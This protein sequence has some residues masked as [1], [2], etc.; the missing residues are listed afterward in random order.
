[1]QLQNSRKSFLKTDLAIK[2]LAVSGMASGCAA[3]IS[4]PVNAA[5][6]SNGSIAFNTVTDNFL[7]EVN[8][9]AGDT[10]TINFAPPVD[11]SSATGPFAAPGFFPSPNN[12]PIASNPI[13]VLSYVGIDPLNASD[14]LY[15][16]NSP[17]S[18][19]FTNGISL[20]IGAGSTFAGS[21]N[22]QNG[23]RFEIRDG[24]GSNFGNTIAGDTTM[25]SGLNF[26]IGALNGSLTGGA[27]VLAT[28]SAVATP[29]PFTI[30]GTLIGGSAALRMRKKLAKAKNK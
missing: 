10:V 15:S 24:V 2:I 19:N 6:L 13:A 20:N 25:P 27:T 18:F 12:Y 29:E 8:P 11:V 4:A 9:V 21:F 16:L 22:I 1:M 3:A 7:A 5:S 30:I 28:T 14:F 23:V 26:T 17:L